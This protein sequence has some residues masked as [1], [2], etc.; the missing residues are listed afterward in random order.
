M[1]RLRIGSDEHKAR[2]CRV[3][4]ETHDAYAPDEIDWPE[5]DAAALARLRGLPFWGEAVGSERTA[6]ARV[7]ALADVERDPLLRE[8]IAMQA[9]EEERHARL[10]DLLLRHYAI[11]YPDGQAEVPRDPEWGFMRMGYGE[12]FDS[13]FAFG[14]FRVAADTGFVPAPLIK[15]F[16]GVMQ[17]E[18]RHI[19]FFSNW[20]AHHGV[21]LPVVEKPWFL[22]RR[23]GGVA[24]QAL[25]RVRTAMQLRDTPDAPDNFTMQVPEE[26]GA[27]TLHS[28]ALTCVREN[29]RRLA[30]YDAELLRPRMVPTLVGL[31]LRFVPGGAARA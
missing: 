17:E 30:L 1:R 27:M 28:L 25:G 26:I 31:A 21:Q 4:V 29:E 18:A 9:F 23:M 5:L 2:F 7:R 19:L 15:I 6:A 13:F 24:L 14:L 12:C 11:P 16:D 22:V 20:A 3:F 8:A 10:L